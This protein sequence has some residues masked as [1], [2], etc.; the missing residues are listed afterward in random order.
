MKELYKA[1]IT[2]IKNTGSKWI[3]FDSGQLDTPDN[4]KALKYPCTLLRFSFIPGDV[5][6]QSDQ[7]ETG[8]ITVR[9]A[10][11]ATGSR[12]S[13][14]VAESV[15]NRSLDWTTTADALYNELQGFA[16]SDFEEMECVGRFQEP[17]TDGL[18]VWKMIFTTARWV[19][20]NQKE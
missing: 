13:A 5:S 3:D 10:F 16:P 8:T 7:R 6:E 18:V 11:D 14:D 15:L 2:P 19:F 1:L 12:T 4:R 9:V 20:K 17:R